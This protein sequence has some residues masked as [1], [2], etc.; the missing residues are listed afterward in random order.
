MAC[1]AVLIFTHSVLASGVS[2]WFHLHAFSTEDSKPFDAAAPDNAPSF[3]VAEPKGD[4]GFIGG[5][6][7]Q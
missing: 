6:G 5:S 2:L 7:K 3:D 4:H 1:Q